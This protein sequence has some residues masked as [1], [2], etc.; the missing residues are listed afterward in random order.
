MIWLGVELISGPEKYSS[1]PEM[2][3]TSQIIAK[4]KPTVILNCLWKHVIIRSPQR[5]DHDV[6]VAHHTF[7]IISEFSRSI[8]WK[9]F[10]TLEAC[11]GVINHPHLEGLQQ[12][13]M[14]SV[15]QF[16]LP[17]DWTHPHRGLGL[18]VQLI[19]QIIQERRSRPSLK[20]TQIH[21][22]SSG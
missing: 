21:M 22:H 1:K 13:S 4:N 3:Q 5:N 15:L 11:F 10:H 12:T 18:S 7:N 20:H 14:A 19:M 2:I 9:H 17:C 16:V 6:R 8:Y